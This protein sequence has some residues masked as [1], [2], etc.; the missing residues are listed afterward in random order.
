MAQPGCGL[1]VALEALHRLVAGELPK[2]QHLERDDAVEFGM[3][4]AIDHTHAA[5]TEFF[6]QFV[7]TKATEPNGVVRD[8]NRN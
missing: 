6:Q 7:L 5:M 1:R 2:Q 3:P 8:W 4:G